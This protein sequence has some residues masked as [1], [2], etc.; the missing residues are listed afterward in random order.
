MIHFV[1]YDASCAQEQRGSRLGYVK[2][3]VV[4]CYFT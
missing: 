2:Y 3:G 1:S 4:L